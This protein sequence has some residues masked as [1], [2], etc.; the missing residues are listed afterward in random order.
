MKQ[1]KG[2]V[3]EFS[4]RR[5]KAEKLANVIQA[6]FGTSAE[7]RNMDRECWAKVVSLAGVNPPSP[8]TKQLAIE[9]LEARE[10]AVE[11]LRAQPPYAAAA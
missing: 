10:Q 7:A 8:E 2:N 11:R 6:A 1:T 3:Y 4:A 5:V 9:L